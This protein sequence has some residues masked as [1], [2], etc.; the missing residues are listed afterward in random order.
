MLIIIT[1]NQ[2]VPVMMDIT[3]KIKFVNNVI[4]NVLNVFLLLLHVH[5]VRVISELLIED[6]FVT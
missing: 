4:I 6:V 5:Y 2:I 1:V 3:L